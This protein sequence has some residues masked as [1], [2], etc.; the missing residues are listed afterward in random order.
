MD[1]SALFGLLTSGAG[2][3]AGRAGKGKATDAWQTA[4]ETYGLLYKPATFWKGPRLSGPLAGNRLTVDI[5]DRNTASAATRFRLGITPLNL[6]LRM[7]RKGFWNSLR[8]RTVV[9]DRAF[10]NQVVVDGRNRLAVQE[11][12]TPER[13]TTVRAFLGGFKGA[14]VTDDE[15]SL[16]IR[17]AVKNSDDMLGAIDA[18]QRVAS[19]LADEPQGRGPEP[20]P[21]PEPEVSDADSIEPADTPADEHDVPADTDAAADTDAPAEP[22]IPAE[23]EVPAVPNVPAEPDA[24]AVPDFEATPPTEMLVSQG[25]MPGIEEFCAAVFAPGLLSYSATQKFRESY[26]GKHIVWTGTLESMT[27]FSFDFDFGSGGGIKAVLTILEGHDAGSRD[28]QAVIGL[29]PGLEGLDDR[30][31][32][33]VAFTGRLLKVDGLAKRVMIA[34]AALRP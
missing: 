19:V 3:L 12:L 10:D 14:V 1:V 20:K 33:P 26:E 7:K 23:P 24:P 8:P 16:R 17:G 25:G 13:R 31:G 2:L 5:K 15:I 30:I 34:D 27:P 22:D 29:P 11:F 9:G 18:M 21:D 4:A 6:G 28:I 32:Q